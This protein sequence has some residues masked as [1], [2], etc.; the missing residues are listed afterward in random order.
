MKRA[1]VPV[2]L[3]CLALAA[4]TRADEIDSLIEQGRTHLQ[5]KNK[6]AAFESFERAIRN[7]ERFPPKRIACAEMLAMGP[8]PARA[9]NA[10]ERILVASRIKDE[11]VRYFGDIIGRC[12]GKKW[13]HAVRIL[14][15]AILDNLEDTGS[16]DRQKQVIKDLEYRMT[17]ELSPDDKKEYDKAVA[18]KKPESVLKA[19][20]FFKARQKLVLAAELLR[21]YNYLLDGADP[22]R[23]KAKADIEALEKLILD[24]CPEEQKKEAEAAI[25]HRVWDGLDIVVSHH[26]IYIG[27]KSFVSRIPPRSMLELDLEYIFLTDML[28]NNPDQ[29]GV[30]ITIFFKELWAFGGGIGGGKTIDIGSVDIKT[31]EISV[32]NFLFFHELCHCLFDTAMIY[33]GFV[34]GVANFG[35]TFAYDAIGLRNEAANGFTGNGGQFTK[36]YLGRDVRYWRIQNYG[37]SAGF[38]LHFIQKYGQ[39]E[40]G[41]W[42]WAKYRTFF[43]LWRRFPL[44]GTDR[45][46]DR[47]R[48]FAHCL[49]QVFGPGVIE[50]LIQFR[51]PILPDELERTRHDVEDVFPLY[52]QG[53]ERMARQDFEG[54]IGAFRET[55]EKGGESPLVALARQQM[56]HAYEQAKD[57]AAQAKLREELGVVMDW[58]CS[59]PFYSDGG[60]S[61]HDVFA[62]E[63]EVDFAKEYTSQF[64]NAKWWA[65]EPRYDG[66]VTYTFHYPG[67][68]AAYAL[69]Y[70]AVPAE[71]PGYLHIGSDDKHALW[72]NHEL[73]EKRDVDHGVLFDQDRYPVMFRKGLNKLLV[74]IA[75]SGGSM[76]FLLRFT[77]RRGKAIPGVQAFPTNREAEIAAAPVFK[78]VRRVYQDEFHNKATLIANWTTGCGSWKIQNKRLWGLETKRNAQWRKF[79]VTPGQEKDAPAN[80]LW[81]KPKNACPERDF[82]V[83]LDLSM[84]GE[85]HPK[86]TVTLDGEGENDGLSGLTL[87]FLPYGEGIDVRLEWYDEMMYWRRTK[88]ETAKEWK[89][90]VTRTSGFV[91][92]TLNGATVFDRASMPVLRS[93]QIGFATFGLE[94]AIERF[95]LTAGGK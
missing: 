52:Q 16:V 26:F 58:R 91:S 73:V 50:D 23:E 37:P 85:S 5:A 67:N 3:L 86:F 95:C 92:V 36:E 14:R 57:V 88:L 55:V 94:P 28:E 20:D 84:N 7:S 13:F 89:L 54:A 49:A 43:R 71:T 32:S 81:L 22:K 70:L 59:G 39:T 2:A 63:Y 68:E 8:F 82:S 83:E 79:V 62:P 31:K 72:L 18:V 74:K 11:K 69:T 40:D 35:A 41:S 19:C 76:G 90:V 93:T 66:L 15:K 10:V 27:D 30:R 46:V 48:Y 51:F 38:W 17:H 45:T 65:G 12:D 75:N 4:P 33:P 24:T 1:F 21:E 53:T 25:K 64:Q 29:D 6:P 61:L 56:L 9:P 44:A 47:I 42:D 78:P 34:E 80:M 87:I 77:D 60:S